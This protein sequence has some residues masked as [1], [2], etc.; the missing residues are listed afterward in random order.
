MRRLRTL[1]R[2]IEAGWGDIPQPLIPETVSVAAQTQM[3]DPPPGGTSRS[4]G[5]APFRSAFHSREELDAWA[6]QMR[7]RN[8]YLI[9]LRERLRAMHASDRGYRPPVEHMRAM[10]R[11]S[12]ETQKNRRWQAKARQEGA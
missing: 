10:A 1:D 5:R 3:P 12:A 6:A 8:A 4:P 11:R 2:L 7:E 9:R